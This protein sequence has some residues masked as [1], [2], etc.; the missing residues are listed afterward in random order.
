M[1]KQPLFMKLNLQ[2]FGD[3]AAEIAAEIQ[4]EVKNLRDMNERSLKEQE[5]KFDGATQETK[6]AIDGANARID[7]LQKKLDA[8]LTEGNRG[9]QTGAGDVDEKAE[10][11]SAAFLKFLREGK[12]GMSREEKALVEDTTGEIIVPEDLDKTIYRELPHL[13]VMRQ[14]AGVRQTNSNRVRRRSLNEVT[15]GWDK[16]ETQS[17]RTL[18]DH[19]STL[20][21]ED[22]YL[23]VENLYGLTKIGEDEL[24]DSDVNLQ[25]YLAES[26]AGARAATEGRAFLR[27]EGHAKLQPEGVLTNTSVA[28]VET[29][30]SLTVTFDDFIELLYA[31]PAQY[32]AKGVFLIPSHLEM[33]AR[34]IKD[35]NGNYIWQ[36]SVAADKPNT[37]FGKPV[38]VQ[39][40][41]DALEAGK[42]VAVFG[43]FKQGYQILDH[44]GLTLTRLNEKF[45]EQDLIGFRAKSRVGGGVVRPKALAKLKV[46]A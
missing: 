9:F 2:F 4:K 26:F 18:A 15:M 20:T 6:N 35:Q 17:A 21:P 39:D 1:T 40:D 41:F 31:V 13:T 44:T 22:A 33:L 23:Y 32:R 8:A 5:T 28:A 11:K 27:G 42:D 29:K 24:Q 12:A 30:G 43:D 45:I 34:T 14:L 19:E 3:S 36:P 7:D 37:L 46:K 16:L 25:A 10:E 38:Y